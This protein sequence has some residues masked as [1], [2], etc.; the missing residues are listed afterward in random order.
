MAICA[1]RHP[2]S[3]ALTSLNL[4]RDIFPAAHC[5]LLICFLSTTNTPQLAA[6]ISY[7]LERGHVMITSKEHRQTFQESFGCNNSTGDIRPLRYASTSVLFQRC[8][9]APVPRL[10]RCPEQ[11]APGVSLGERDTQP[12]FERRELMADRLWR[13]SAPRRM[14]PTSPIATRCSRWFCHP[15]R[16]GLLAG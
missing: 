3:S 6:G 9:R 14:L 1:S 10:T 8:H 15:S 12:L 2:R 11:R 7:F 16:Q 5:V 4:F 13:A